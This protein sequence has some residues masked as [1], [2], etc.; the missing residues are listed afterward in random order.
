VIAT[1]PDYLLR[2]VSPSC[3]TARATALGY[4]GHQH[5]NRE[6][7]HGMTSDNLWTQN[8][9][10]KQAV[11]VKKIGRGRV[12]LSVQPIISCTERPAAI[13]PTWLLRSQIPKRSLLSIWKISSQSGGSKRAVLSRSSTA[14]LFA[15]A[16]VRAT[17]CRTTRSVKIPV[18]LMMEAILC[19][20]DKLELEGG[21][22]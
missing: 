8:I 2:K 13:R 11:I 15:S 21:S 6:E 20:A 14:G 5:S 9:D 22:L 3:R 19:K 4:Q 18:V 10:I 12:V 17:N 1:L 7:N 16:S